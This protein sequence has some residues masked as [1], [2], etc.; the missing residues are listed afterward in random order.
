MKFISSYNCRDKYFFSNKRKAP[1]E[2]LLQI[3]FNYVSNRVFHFIIRS[4][5]SELL[6]YHDLKTPDV[7]TN[8]ETKFL[9]MLE[10]MFKGAYFLKQVFTGTRPG[11]GSEKYLTLGPGPGVKKNFQAGADAGALV[12]VPFFFGFLPKMKNNPQIKKCELGNQ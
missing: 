4:K 1:K 11:S 3:L 12:R 7:N 10:L 6:I 5:C 9:S 2:I 8:S